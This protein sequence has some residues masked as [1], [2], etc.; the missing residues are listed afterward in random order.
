MQSNY[1]FT[2]NGI[3]EE[4]KWDSIKKKRECPR[5]IR[6][7]GMNES[8]VLMSDEL[9]THDESE[10]NIK[11]DTYEKD[12]YHEQVALCQ[13]AE[14]SWDEQVMFGGIPSIQAS[15]WILERHYL[16]EKLK[17]SD[18]NELYNHVVK[19]VNVVEAVGEGG[20]FDSYC[21]SLA[22][23]VKKMLSNSEM[24]DSGK[25]LKMT[26]KISDKNFVFKDNINKDYVTMQSDNKLVKVLPD[27]CY[28]WGMPTKVDSFLSYVWGKSIS[29]NN[30][31]EAFNEEINKRFHRDS[32]IVNYK[33]PDEKG[34]FS[35]LFS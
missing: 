31:M 22:R 33:K 7:F 10:T 13:L 30:V 29:D 20:I 12:I 9:L 21:V 11:F 18:L 8:K 23:E 3:R 26:P 2:K 25:T 24:T 16:P 27:E 35:K 34:F 4:C 17:D 14:R 19:V 1:G 5:H 6:H 32:R 28:V 15:W